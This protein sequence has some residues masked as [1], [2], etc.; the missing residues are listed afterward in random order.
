MYVYIYMDFILMVFQPPKMTKLRI[1]GGYISCFAGFGRS[2][3]VSDLA[4]FPGPRKEGRRLYFLSWGVPQQVA[5]I[6][7]LG[8]APYSTSP[9][10]QEAR[11][12]ARMMRMRDERD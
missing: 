7:D 6:S 10:Y 2:G 11:Q 1:V 9:S 4:T 8:A 5:A 3:Y 12:K